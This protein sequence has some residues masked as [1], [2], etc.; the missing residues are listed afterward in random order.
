MWLSWTVASLVVV[1]CW[2]FAFGSRTAAHSVPLYF[3]S[4]EWLTLEV[5]DQNEGSGS[6][7]LKM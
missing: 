5:K 7:A 2:S 1:V 4:L 3:S 6:I